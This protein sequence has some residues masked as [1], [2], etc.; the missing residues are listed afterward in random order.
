[1]RY[2]FIYVAMFMLIYLIASFVYLT[3]LP[4]Q[5]C[6]VT[7]GAVAIVPL[8]ITG[9]ARIFKAVDEDKL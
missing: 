4:T 1:M 7:R 9:L 5:W 3:F 8:I 2:L 6:E